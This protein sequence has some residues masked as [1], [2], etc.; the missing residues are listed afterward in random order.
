MKRYA[1]L[2]SSAV[3]VG[4]VPSSLL[5]CSA[6]EPAAQQATLE[7]REY[8]FAITGMHCENCVE[9]I[10]TAVS[11]LD[12]VSHCDVSLEDETAVI[13]A[14]VADGEVLASAISSLGFGVKPIQPPDEP[15]D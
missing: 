10:T 6:Q 8:R 1:A 15:A 2:V 4:I 9:S 13:S 5:S 12:G 3:L 7:V 14:A 11:K